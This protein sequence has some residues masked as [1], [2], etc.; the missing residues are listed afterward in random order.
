MSTKKK[1]VA[2]PPKDELSSARRMAGE[3]LSKLRHHD[4]KLVAMS[5]AVSGESKQPHECDLDTPDLNA[6]LRECLKVL[7]R[8]TATTGLVGR[9]LG[10]Q[11]P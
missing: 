11:E 2:P 3:L 5:A 8:V 6:M 9:R 7:G 10:V 4:S 1:P